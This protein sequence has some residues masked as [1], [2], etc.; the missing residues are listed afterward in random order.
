MKSIVLCLGL[1][2]PNVV[3]GGVLTG[4]ATT[5]KLA[6]KTYQVS[7]EVMDRIE[8]EAYQYGS[9]RVLNIKEP[10]KLERIHVRHG[11]REL[12]LEKEIKIREQK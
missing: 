3:F 8:D 11:K 2:I 12:H 7:S 5:N 10:L 1:F 4:G 9:I 6:K